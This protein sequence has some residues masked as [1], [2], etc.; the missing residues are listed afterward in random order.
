[1]SDGAN[2]SNGKTSNEMVVT[3]AMMNDA[4]AT[5]THNG[6]EIVF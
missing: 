3:D 6:G 1:M 4:K 5:E 2:E